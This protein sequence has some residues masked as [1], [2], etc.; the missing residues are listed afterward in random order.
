MQL[1]HAAAD[2]SAVPG[3]FGA[4][5]VLLVGCCSQ[6][7]VAVWDVGLQQQILAVHSPGLRLSGLLS[8]GPGAA[9]VAAMRTN[10]AVAG[11]S[12]AAAASGVHQHQQESTG[13]QQPVVCLAVVSSLDSSGRGAATG[14]G[15]QLR[16]VVLY[17][18]GDTQM[19]QP[20]VCAGAGGVSTAV[21]SGTTAAAVAGCGTL[22]AWDVLSGTRHMSMRPRCSSAGTAGT[23]ALLPLDAAMGA[24]GGG[25]AGVH[26]KSEVGPGNL[27]LAGSSSGALSV[28][29]L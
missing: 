22:Q 26:P 29:M 28:A 9:A 12:A 14:P 21:L 27:L 19:G 17:G 20:L 11:R 4:R 8:P 25:E 1:A 6:G 16:A 15:Q 5:R 10:Q 2:P 13:E 7:P 23:V 24:V 18:D 3:L